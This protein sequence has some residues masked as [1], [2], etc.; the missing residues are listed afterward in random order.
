M[1]PYYLQQLERVLRALSRQDDARRSTQISDEVVDVILYGTD[2]EQTFAYTSRGGKDVG[3]PGLVRRRRQQPAAPLQRNLE[4]L[5]QGRHRE[6]HVGLDV[7]GCKGARLKPEALAVTIGERNIDALTRMPIE[8]AR[9]VLSR[10][11][12][13]PSGRSRSRIRSSKRFGRGSAS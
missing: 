1:N 9:E 10:A 7:P 5:R 8:T 2:R 11:A 6:V 13:S 3:V 12:R 4:R